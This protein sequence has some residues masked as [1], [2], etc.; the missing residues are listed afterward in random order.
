M[1]MRESVLEVSHLRK[2]CQNREVLKDVSFSPE[3]GTAATP[4]GPN[5]AGKTT[6]I[7]ILAGPVIP[8]AMQ[9]EGK[10]GEN[11]FRL[12]ARRFL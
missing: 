10:E 12:E 1:N 7:P 6:L 2:V 9:E 4:M 8:E 5:G 11:P 3:P